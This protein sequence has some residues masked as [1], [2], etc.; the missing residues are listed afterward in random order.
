M[1]HCQQALSLTI[2]D[3]IDKFHRNNEDLTVNDVL[4][5][6]ENVR[7][8]LTEALLAQQDQLMKGA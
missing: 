1:T 8:V 4:V 2:T 3:G 6:L 5:A 7:E